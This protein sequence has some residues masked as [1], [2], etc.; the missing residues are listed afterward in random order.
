[1]PGRGFLSPWSALMDPPKKL[2]TRSV[3]PELFKENVGAGG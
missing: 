1:M 3:I 2:E